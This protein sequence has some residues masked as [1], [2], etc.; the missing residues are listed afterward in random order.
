MGEELPEL[1]HERQ[2]AIDE[3]QKI[4][5]Q[6]QGYRL[7]WIEWFPKLQAGERDRITRLTGTLEQLRSQVREQDQAQ[8]RL[9][10][11]GA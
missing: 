11:G 3:L 7:Q 1:M 4:D 2:Q 5:T 8:T 6:L 9:V 10:R